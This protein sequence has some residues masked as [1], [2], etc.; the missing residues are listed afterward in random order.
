MGTSAMAEATKV[1]T[2]NAVGVGIGPLYQHPQ[3]TRTVGP[4]FANLIPKPGVPFLP[5]RPPMGQAHSPPHPSN[6]PTLGDYSSRSISSLSMLLPK[7]PTFLQQPAN[8]IPNSPLIGQVPALDLSRFPQ[9][10]HLQA[11]LPSW[12]LAAEQTAVGFPGVASNPGRLVGNMCEME[13]AMGGNANALPTADQFAQSLTSLAEEQKIVS[14]YAQDVTINNAEW[15]E[16]MAKETLMK[17]RQITSALI[18]PTPADA[19]IVSLTT[20]QTTPTN[21]ST[22]CALSEREELIRTLREVAEENAQLSHQ[23][24]KVFAKVVRPLGDVQR[25]AVQKSFC[26]SSPAVGPI[27]SSAL[28]PSSGPAKGPSSGPTKGSHS[29]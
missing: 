10:P 16:R 21:S 13:V 8:F 23:L 27:S 2:F 7:W 6:S 22:T 4:H 15:V 9:L 12:N 19:A 29:S 28:G 14:F 26:P 11:Q 20:T 5:V 18:I 3:I 1:G 25:T 24:A 17:P